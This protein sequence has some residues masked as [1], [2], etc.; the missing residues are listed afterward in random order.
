M[1]VGTR[2]SQ[3]YRASSDAEIP[4]KPKRVSTVRVNEQHAV[5]GGFRGHQCQHAFDMVDVALR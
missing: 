4:L 5:A 2:M 1:G 3:S